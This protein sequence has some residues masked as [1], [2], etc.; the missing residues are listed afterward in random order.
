MPGAEAKQMLQT[1]FHWGVEDSAPGTHYHTDPLPL[2]RASLSF[3]SAQK[4]VWQEACEL[5]LADKHEN[6]A[7]FH[8]I[9]LAVEQAGI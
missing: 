7:H 4:K 9:K 5:E 8:K 1:F 3:T 6:I 2:R